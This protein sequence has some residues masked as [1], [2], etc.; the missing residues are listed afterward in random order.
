[1]NQQVNFYFEAFLA[2]EE[3]GQLKSLLEAHKSKKKKKRFLQNTAF[4][5]VASFIKC[6]FSENANDF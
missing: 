2:S 1:M 4:F 3:D 5:M 6:G